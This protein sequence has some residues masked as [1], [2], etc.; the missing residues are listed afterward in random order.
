M[1]RICGIVFA[2]S[3]I[4]TEK[5]PVSGDWHPAY[6]SYQLRMA[7]TSLRRI[8]TAHGYKP[9]SASVALRKPWP[10]MERLIAAALGKPPREIWPSRYDSAGKH[11]TGPKG[12]YKAKHITRGDAVNVQ[13][14]RAA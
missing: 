3:K 8:S 2:M 14:C 5:N 4:D 10:K 13:K 11:K 12:G 6:I 9:N 7:R 1:P